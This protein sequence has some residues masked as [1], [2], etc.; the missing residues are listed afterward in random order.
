MRNDDKTHRMLS[1]IL[2][3]LLLVVIWMAVVPTAIR[4]LLG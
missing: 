1:G 2:A 4:L 3:A